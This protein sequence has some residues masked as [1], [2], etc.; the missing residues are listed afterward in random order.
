MYFQLLSFLPLIITK[1][2]DENQS[3]PKGN[4]LILGK[5]IS[6]TIGQDMMMDMLIDNVTN[7]HKTWKEDVDVCEWEGVKCNEEKEILFRVV[8]CIV[9]ITLHYLLSLL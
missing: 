4:Q 2:C 7:K 3:F 6:L 9:V 5:I 8:G 1:Y